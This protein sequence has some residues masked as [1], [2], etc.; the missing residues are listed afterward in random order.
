MD[1]ARLHAKVVHASLA[2]GALPVDGAHKATLS[3]DALLTV[4]AVRVRL[5][6]AG[7]A[8]AAK[9]VRLTAKV[10]H[11]ATLGLV[12]VHLA[13]GIGAALNLLAGVLAEEEATGV[14]DAGR[15]GGTVSI[16]I[17]AGVWVSTAVLALQVRVT[18]EVRWAG[19]GEGA[20][21]VSTA[22]Q[23]VAG[24]GFAETNRSTASA[25]GVTGEARQTLAVGIV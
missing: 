3:V 1:D 10:L 2:K 18:D 20:Q 8:R 23:F 12:I 4:A 21:R 9:G 22:G 13:D 17:R 5:A 16:A 7:N 6:E 19:A 25:I 24:V 14:R 15:I 11:A